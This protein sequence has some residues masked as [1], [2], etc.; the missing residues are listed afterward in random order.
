MF[1]AGGMGF[2][3]IV[4]PQNLLSHPFRFPAL[5]EMSRRCREAEKV[6]RNRR[7]KWPIYS[8]SFDVVF[9]GGGILAV[10]MKSQYL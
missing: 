5:C 3:I 4:L 2:R 8:E 9:M 6:S 10:S 7:G 1:T